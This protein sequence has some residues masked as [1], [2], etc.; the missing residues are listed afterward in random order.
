MPSLPA[1]AAFGRR[2]W[3]VALDAI[4]AGFGI[5]AI[6]IVGDF[7][8]NVPGSG[9]VLVVL[10][11][12]IIFLYEPLLVWG[13]GATIGQRAANLRVVDDATGG[14]P[15]FWRAFVRFVLKTVLGLPSFIAMAF[16]RRH[17]ALHDKLTHTTVQIRDLDRAAAGDYHAE[18]VKDAPDPAMPSPLRRIVIIVLYSAGLFLIG[19]VEVVLFVALFHAGD[20]DVLNSLFALFWTAGTLWVVIAGWQGLLIGARRRVPDRV[21]E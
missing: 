2:L 7:A 20:I 16:T 13:F 21:E 6:A 14:N 4:V 17:Q 3:A 1:Y 19:I 15:P 9:R 18:R 5:V 11:Y 10:L 8:R 12:A